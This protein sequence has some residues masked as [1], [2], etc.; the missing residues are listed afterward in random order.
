ML[1]SPATMSGGLFKSWNPK[2]A[3]LK[4]FYSSGTKCSQ[5]QILTGM[6]AVRTLSCLTAMDTFHHMQSEDVD[7][8]P[9]RL[10]VYYLIF[11]H[12]GF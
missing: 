8:F 7:E 2:R 3:T 12:P 6:D 1:A 10:R 4:D 11:Y 5:L 9:C